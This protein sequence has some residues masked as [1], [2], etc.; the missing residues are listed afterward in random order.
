MNFK[1]DNWLSEHCCKMK[2]MKIHRS[3]FWHAEIGKQKCNVLDEF[4]SKSFTS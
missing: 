3:Y 1:L 2:N 4:D